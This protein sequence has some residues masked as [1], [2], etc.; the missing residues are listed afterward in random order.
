MISS[1][2]SRFTVSI[3]IIFLLGTISFAQ[4]VTDRPD[5]TESSYAVGNN[6]L[7]IES[8]ILIAYTGEENSVRQILAPTNLLRYG[9]TDKLEIRFVSQFETLKFG[10]SSISGISNLEIG[11]K[12]NL[13]DNTEGKNL[14]IGFLAH[15]VTPYGS[16][17]FSSEDW[18]AITRILISH[19]LNQ[20][21]SIGYN[22]GYNKL[23]GSSNGDFTYTIAAGRAVN[24]KI[25]IYFEPFGE[26][27]EMEDFIIN[28]DAG[29]TY[30]PTPDIQLD[31]SF[32]TGINERMN[33]ISVGA[34]WL[35]TSE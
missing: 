28:F 10:S 15:A 13:V 23:A 27:R 32:G 26:F 22:F 19:D 6:N 9:L 18:G 29:F 35:M 8:G 24:D 25:G 20:D 33:Y 5:Q 17:E 21:W 14:A 2:Y 12:I 11:T 34:S 30:L 3:S 4:I 7:Q 31:F 1:L 16:A